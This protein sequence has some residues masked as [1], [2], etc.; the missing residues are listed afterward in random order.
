ML[1]L[2]EFLVVKFFSSHVQWDGEPN[3]F[4]G[5]LVIF[6]YKILSAEINKMGSGFNIKGLKWRFNILQ[7]LLCTNILVDLIQISY[8]NS[9]EMI[10]INFLIMHLSRTRALRQ[11][12]ACQGHWATSPV[13]TFLVIAIRIPSS[14]NISSLTWDDLWECSSLSLQFF[15]STCHWSYSHKS[16]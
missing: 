14:V 5:W 9:P 11:G 15:W 12:K 2:D 10:Q 3:I 4:V 1:V 7:G 8:K 13:C 16:C 6:F